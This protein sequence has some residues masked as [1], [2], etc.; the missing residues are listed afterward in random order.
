MK[1][2]KIARM[3]PIESARFRILVA[4]RAAQRSLQLLATIENPDRLSADDK[5]LV[6]KNTALAKTIIACSKPAAVAA[7]SLDEL[8]QILRHTSSKSR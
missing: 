8:K 7:M 1:R 2:P 3:A 4:R 5:E 6:A